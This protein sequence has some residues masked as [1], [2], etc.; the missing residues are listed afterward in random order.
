[1][2][3]H[4]PFAIFN[5]AS[6]KTTYEADKAELEKGIAEVQAAL[7]V[8]SGYCAKDD[9]AHDSAEGA[10]SGIIALGGRGGRL[11]EDLGAY[12]CR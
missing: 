4:Q 8:L 2:K 3:I 7:K 1:M 6:Q 9:K 5:K 12:Q 10:A 11:H